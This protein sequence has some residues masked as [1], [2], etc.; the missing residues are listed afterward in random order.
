MRLNPTMYFGEA[1]GFVSWVSP[2]NH[3]MYVQYAKDMFNDGTLDLKSPDAPR[4]TIVTTTG[5]WSRETE[6]G[7]KRA[8]Q[9][10][11]TEFDLYNASYSVDFS[12]N[13]PE[14]KHTVH[15][16]ER[17]NMVMVYSPSKELLDA[18]ESSTVSY[19]TVMDAFVKMLVGRTSYNVNT[20]ELSI[21]SPA[22]V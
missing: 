22:R 17:V 21:T 4:I 19:L 18:E 2:A 3:G 9:A 10:N 13:Y 1:S 7:G 5:N 16:R 8:T 15:V 20:A 6:A 14:Q 12:F 11:V